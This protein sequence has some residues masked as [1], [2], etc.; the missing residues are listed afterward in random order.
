MLFLLY[1][2]PLCSHLIV[3]TALQALLSQF[4]FIIYFIIPAFRRSYHSHLFTIHITKGGK[5]MNTSE[6]HTDSTFDSNFP[7]KFPDFEHAHGPVPYCLTNDYLFRAVLQQ[8]NPAL[9]GLICSLLHLSEK[10]VI[11]V[12]ITNPI[13]LGESIKDKEFRLDVNVNLNNNTFINLEMQL[14]NRLNWKNRSLVYLCRSF[15]RL[16]HGQDYIDIKPV[17]H[18]A[19]L[20]YSL[21]PENPEF[22][23]SYQLMNQKNN[24][25]Y[26]SNFTLNVIDLTHINLATEEDKKFRIDEWA[27]LFKAKTWEEVH[28][29][30][31]KNEYLQQA[32]GTMFRLTAE[33]QIRK[34]CRDREEYYQDMRN[35]ERYIAQQEGDLTIA[36]RALEQME[37]KLSDTESELSDAQDEILKLQ[38]IADWARAHGYMEN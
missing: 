10:E 23:A 16:S 29:L 26:S 28:M 21:F 15:D 14:G 32:A 33:E 7:A 8:S 34:R 35:Y 24:T 9:K 31:E 27:R 1:S 20:D 36:K 11:S 3:A 25:L 5:S 4:F 38:K 37:S 22:C 30:A 18:I 2:I 6:K 19:F 12:E 13:I 17:I